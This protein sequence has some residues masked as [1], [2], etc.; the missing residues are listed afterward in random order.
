M[1]KSRGLSY[2]SCK[3]QRYKLLVLFLCLIIFVLIT[4]IV[5]L[6]SFAMDELNKGLVELHV[7]Y[8]EYQTHYKNGKE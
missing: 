4:H 5:G 7:E 2:F 1:C 8:Y 3:I 6:N